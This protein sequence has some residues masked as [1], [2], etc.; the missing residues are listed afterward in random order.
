MLRRDDGEWVS[1]AWIVV[2]M[3]PVREVHL[4]DPEVVEM[5][6]NLR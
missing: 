1:G 6:E 3:V 4:A 5:V 2:L